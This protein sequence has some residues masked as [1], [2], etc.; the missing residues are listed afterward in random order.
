MLGRQAAL[1]ENSSVNSLKMSDYKKPPV[2]EVIITYRFIPSSE[3]P[4][5]GLETGDAFIKQFPELPVPMRNIAQ[6]VRQTFEIKD[7]KSQFELMPSIIAEVAAQNDNK[8]D[9]LGVGENYLTYHKLRV[10]ENYPRYSQVKSK[11]N[12]YLPT[13]CDFWKSS[14]IQTVVLSY[15]DIVEVPEIDADIEKYFRL[16]LEHNVKYGKLKNFDVTLN[17]QIESNLELT[18]QF[19]RL[20]FLEPGNS[21]FYIFW[22]CI[23]NISG[24][25]NYEQELDGVHEYVRKFFE[26]GLTEECKKLFN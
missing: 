15:L 7:A 10:G 3:T 12:Q 14:V 17:Y 20:V 5:W 8:T 11:I 18:V 1:T 6:H 26:D 22:H 9:I 24:Q 2:V 23:K 4:E 25:D 16:G 13:Y 19:K 21:Q